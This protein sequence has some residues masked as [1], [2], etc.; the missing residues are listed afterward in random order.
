[1]VSL[2]NRYMEGNL[3]ISEGQNEAG[4]RLGGDFQRRLGRQ[5]RRCLRKRVWRL[6][7]ESSI[8][9]VAED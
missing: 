2:E 8:G 1:M 5:L 9:T 3:A 7:A 4:E 6:P